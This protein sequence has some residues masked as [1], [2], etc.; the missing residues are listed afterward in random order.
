MIKNIGKLSI[1]TNS[2]I[3]VKPHINIVFYGN[4][5]CHV[6]SNIFNSIIDKTKYNIKDVSNYKLI[7]NNDILPEEVFKN[8]DVLIYQPLNGH[9][10]LDSDYI[11]SNIISK[12]CITVSFPYLYFLGYFPDYIDLEDEK[13]PYQYKGINDI[14]EKN[15]NVSKGDLLDIIFNIMK[16][17]YVSGN[18]IIDKFNYSINKLKE[19]EEKCDL[20]YSQFIIDNYKD[21]KLFH[22]PNHPS[23]VVLNKLFNDIII[24]LNE[25]CVDKM[26]MK[27]L[28]VLNINLDG[29]YEL[30]GVIHNMII[31]DDVKKQLNLNFD[32]DYCYLNFK[33]LQKKEYFEEYIK[34]K[35]RE[36]I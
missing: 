27:E 36:I 3:T 15:K 23:N 12:N 33:N 28:L 20:K 16:G 29:I 25:K 2:L 14:I 5:Q 17:G 6:L 26:R 31:F 7:K 13:L 32:E 4:C 21:K 8:A 22:S 19:K 1:C 18:E 34:L 30:L 9:G 24:K 11:I 10:K 35:T